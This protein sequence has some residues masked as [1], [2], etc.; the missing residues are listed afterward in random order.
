MPKLIISLDTEDALTPEAGEGVVYLLNLFEKYSLQGN[1]CLVADLA[2]RWKK[3]NRTDIMDRLTSNHVVAFH[4]TRHSAP[5]LDVQLVEGVDFWT[6]VQRIIQDEQAGYNFIE[7][8]TG[9]KPAAYVIPGFDWSAQSVVAM[10]KMGLPLF[11]NEQC[12][13]GRPGFPVWMCNEL[14]VNYDLGI[15]EF[16]KIPDWVSALKESIAQLLD[17]RKPE[18]YAII[19]CHTNRIVTQ[20]FSDVLNYI[21]GKNPPADKLLPSPIRS[22]E[23]IQSIVAGLDEV[24]KYISQRKDVVLANYHD[25]YKDFSRPSVVKCPIDVLVDLA[26]KWVSTA[27][28]SKAQ[29]LWEDISPADLVVTIAS[30]YNNPILE[31]YSV[32]RSIGPIDTPDVSEPGEI[33]WEKVPQLAQLVTEYWNEKEAIPHRIEFDGRILGTHAITTIL[34]KSFISK[35]NGKQPKSINWPY[36]DT[37]PPQGRLPF[38]ADLKLNG[39]WLIFSPD[40]DDTEVVE[41]LKLQSWSTSQAKLNSQ[42]S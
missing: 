9:H 29:P 18:E 39:T 14:I 8:Y 41:K 34:A 17:S 33:D 36:G 28:S 37:L 7:E 24:F 22:E 25:Y 35:V 3:E 27:G 6:G 31:E 1:F 4:S 42:R 16:F 21:G 26:E 19:Y 10:K 15:D 30:N 12:L 23:E 32:V 13:I 11:V 40:F 20:E 5:P 2:R 38:F